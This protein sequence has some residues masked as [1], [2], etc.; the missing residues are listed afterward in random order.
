V[1]IRA[2]RYRGRHTAAPGKHTAKR[3]NAKYQGTHRNIERG[4]AGYEGRHQAVPEAPPAPRPNVRVK[5]PA[6]T[7]TQLAAHA[8]AYPP[9]R[10][11]IRQTP[12]D[13]RRE[14]ERNYPPKGR[15]RT[16]DP[17]AKSRAQL[18]ERDRVRGSQSHPVTRP[19]PKSN[20]GARSNVKARG[21]ARRPASVLPGNPPAGRHRHAEQPNTGW[22]FASGFFK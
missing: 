3:Q 13:D 6:S 2:P 11:G 22:S 15:S 20:E 7:R 8:A 5:Q 19:H 4:P 17:T 14:P 21:S 18:A 9:R 1:P 10:P 16:N 12:A